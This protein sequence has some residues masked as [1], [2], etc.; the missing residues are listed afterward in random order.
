[1]HAFAQ[2]TFPCKTSFRAHGRLALCTPLQ[3][4][5]TSVCALPR[6]RHPHDAGVSGRWWGRC[7]IKFDSSPYSTAKHSRAVIFVLEAPFAPPNVCHTPVASTPARASLSSGRTRR[8][9]QPRSVRPLSRP[10]RPP[11]P[12]PSVRC[13]PRVSRFLY[14]IT[15][16][17]AAGKLQDIGGQRGEA[18]MWVLSSRIVHDLLAACHAL[19]FFQRIALPLQQ[20]CVLAASARTIALSTWSLLRITATH[21][22]GWLKSRET[23]VSRHLIL[24]ALFQDHRV[25]HAANGR[26]AWA[27]RIW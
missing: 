19:L 7:W 6:A 16:I 26:D 4:A 9:S 24:L 20:R 11:M 1:M 10:L 17:G 27:G 21:A 13:P 14:K 22:N 5:Q 12:P 2:S 25:P 18:A 8:S 23:T 3:W 15:P